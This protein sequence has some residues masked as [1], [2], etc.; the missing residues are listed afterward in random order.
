M[1]VSEIEGR[2]EIIPIIAGKLAPEMWEKVIEQLL[3]RTV[4]PRLLEFVAP[5]LPA[6]SGSG[7]SQ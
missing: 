3:G 7:P 6:A 1:A 5:Y 2:K 4:N